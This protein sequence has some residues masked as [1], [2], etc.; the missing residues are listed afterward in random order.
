M[1]RLESAAKQGFYPTPETVSDL[2]AQYIQPS[3][4]LFYALDPCCGYGTALKDLVNGIGTNG[5]GYG[6]EINSVRAKKSESV[7][8]K[9]LNIEI[10][11]LDFPKH[12]TPQ[13]NRLYSLRREYYYL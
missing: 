7:L 11:D 1:A 4:K 9:V 5:K 2:I 3:D 6:I 13:S 10:G 8:D 12:L